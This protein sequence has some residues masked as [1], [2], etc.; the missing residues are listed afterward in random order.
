LDGKQVKEIV[1]R[2]WEKVD[3]FVSSC[4]PVLNDRQS[5]EYAKRM[6]VEEES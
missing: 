6:K 4:G 5:E 2:E 3:R 1:D